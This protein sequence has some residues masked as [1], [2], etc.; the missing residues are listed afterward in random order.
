METRAN[1]ILIGAF[2]LFAILG[3]L[4]FFV[5]LASVQI[6]RQY[7]TY[8]VLFE[9]VSGLDASGDVFF[10]G[11]SVG[12]VIG[13]RIYDQD[14]SKVF[15]TIEVDSE[16][17]I[18]SDT[19]AQLQSQGVTGV[20]Y[21]SLSGGTPGAPPLVENSDGWR[22]IPSRRSTVQTLVQEAPTLLVEATALLEQFQELTGPEN[23]AYVSSILRNLDASSGRLDQALND[24][25][26][27]T[28]TIREATGQ[29]TVFTGK[30]EDIAGAATTTLE[31]VDE[32]LVAAKDAFES[33]DT[34]LAKSVDAIDSAEG[35]FDQARQLLSEQVPEILAQVSEA[36]KLTNT[37]IADLQ[38]RSGATLDGFGQTA[39]LLN[40]RLIELEET[41]KGANTAFVAVTEASDSFDQLVDGDGA[42]LVAEAREVLA[43]ARTGITTFN[44]VV[45][46]DVPAIMADIRQGVATAGQA[47]DKVAADLTAL[48]DRFDP[49]ADDTQ[50]AIASANA[51]FEKAQGSL[52]GLDETLK[53]AE[54][55]LVTA[56]SA[57]ESATG[58]L[59]TDIGPMMAD[60]RQATDQISL[61][62]SDVTKDMPA[63]TQDL[64]AL[65]AR[66]DKVV[67]QI[68]QAVA[69]STPGIDDFARKGLPEF[70]RLA[71]EART[72]VRTLGDLARRIERNPA[73]F[74]LDD[75][76]PEYRK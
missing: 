32:T 10:N 16:T 22:I 20:A 48:G 69:Q 53:V 54:T 24:F 68:Q 15:T 72:L 41:L 46:D 37:A 40:A 45:A 66:S 36:A 17:P 9:D 74:L 4:G 12:K 5:W 39:D 42:L 26:E 28:G 65:I 67:Q 18:R 49:L 70:T 19:V 47:I 30:L 8:G 27:I 38:S 64:R 1:F 6:D 33:A 61:A 52:E 11:I 62:V 43:D 2:T 31:N 76:V 34:A 57:F 3:T 56:Q 59:D 7:T 71:S 14:P 29:I 25:S 58:V 13:L 55:T 73:R 60:I 50:Q 44:Q 23:Q 21:I 63:I 35:T 51:M 75:R